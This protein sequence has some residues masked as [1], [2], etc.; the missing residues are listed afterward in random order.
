MNLSVYW[1]LELKWDKAIIKWQRRNNPL[2]QNF[3]FGVIIW[4]DVRV[5]LLE[6]YACNKSVTGYHDDDKYTLAASIL[7]VQYATDRKYRVR[8]GR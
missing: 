5:S 3:Q 2:A 6:T 4:C 7:S 8:R 1:P